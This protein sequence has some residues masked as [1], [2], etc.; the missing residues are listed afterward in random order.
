MK[1]VSQ[2]TKTTSPIPGAQ[3]SSGSAGLAIDPPVSE[4]IQ[5]QAT[6]S[7]ALPD[8]LKAGVEALSGLSMDDV[9]VHT[10]SSK[11]AKL[12]A[13]AYAQG[14]DIHLGPGQERHLPHEAWHVVQQKEGRVKPT[15]LISQT[16]INNKTHLE[17]EADDP[18][19]KAARNRQTLGARSAGVRPFAVPSSQTT[20]G[21]VQGV[22]EYSDDTINTKEE[23]E[24]LGGNL[25]KRLVGTKTV[26]MTRSAFI[27][28]IV[29]LATTGD[30]GSIGDDYFSRLLREGRIN[31]TFSFEVNGRRIESIH[32]PNANFPPNSSYFQKRLETEKKKPRQ[33]KGESDDEEESLLVPDLSYN[34]LREILV[35]RL[36]GQISQEEITKAIRAGVQKFSATNKDLEL[37][38]SVD[39][40]LQLIPQHL[41]K[42]QSFNRGQ[43]QDTEENRTE[44]AFRSL[45]MEI[46]KQMILDAS[47]RLDKIV[48]PTSDFNQGGQLSY[49][50][51]GLLDV[52]RPLSNSVFG[53]ETYKAVFLLT[54]KLLRKAYDQSQ[55]SLS[56]QQKKS[57]KKTAKPTIK[58]QITEQRKFLN[59]SY[60]QVISEMDGSTIP[61]DEE[62]DFVQEHLRI[63][64]NDENDSFDESYS[65]ESD[66]DMLSD[67][68]F[69]HESDDIFRAS[70]KRSTVL[71]SLGLLSKM[72]SQ[73][74]LLDE[75][76]E[77]N[78]KK[79]QDQH[80]RIHRR[81]R[82]IDKKYS[83]RFSG[84]TKELTYFTQK[85]KQIGTHIKKIDDERETLEFFTEDD[86]WTG[87]KALLGKVKKDHPLFSQVSKFNKAHQKVRANTTEYKNDLKKLRKSIRDNKKQQQALQERRRFLRA[88]RKNAKDLRET[89]SNFYASTPIEDILQERE[90]SSTWK[91]RYPDVFGNL[92]PKSMETFIYSNKR[93]RDEK[94]EK[95]KPKK[96]PRR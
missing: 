91:T 20:Q 30:Y 52:N 80:K 73:K 14:A 13:L 74:E 83:E 94:K 51:P 50:F 93:R 43:L 23:A 72:T 69:Y 22:F 86:E 41:L 57:K 46:S 40:D 68:E 61:E 67:E 16:P 49:A 33:K 78:N 1:N 81:T 17:D 47:N 66:D 45:A 75:P 3:P 25:Y 4:P 64:Y 21:V 7:D 24:E 29:E 96:R 6:R 79:Y 56:S 62:K 5:M 35:Q 70:E 26:K 11:P 9:R 34:D 48:P 55:V 2:K 39:I 89:V 63:P 44:N 87:V 15:S 18:G 19:N 76:T 88:S 95:K 36:Q 60:F 85:E 84:I 71:N 37:D 59:P 58:E 12:N 77:E 31:E 27:E 38:P 32:N 90:E 42:Y 8:A 65:S 10:N 53:G 92:G 28:M 54:H 82:Q